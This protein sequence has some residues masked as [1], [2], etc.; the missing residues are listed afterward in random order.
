MVHA[1][2]MYGFAGGEGVQAE[3]WDQELN[4]RPERA[5]LALERGVEVVRAG[6]YL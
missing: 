2:R 5:R 4:H 1:F 6:A 3:V